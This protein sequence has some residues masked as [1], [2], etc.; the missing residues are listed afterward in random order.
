MILPVDMVDYMERLS[1]YYSLLAPPS[2]GGYVQR[3]WERWR[4]D[5]ER[6]LLQS[7]PDDVKAVL[8]PH[9]LR[10]MKCMLWVLASLE[11]DRRKYAS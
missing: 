2:V 5:A 9:C 6:F 3:Q 11:H 1:P 10:R 4:W 7:T 8:R